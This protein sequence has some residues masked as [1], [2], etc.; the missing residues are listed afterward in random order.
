MPTQIHKPRRKSRKTSKRKG[1]VAPARPSRLLSIDEAAE[2]L[3]VAKVT[4]RRWTNTG[5]LRCV[6]MCDRGDRRFRVE[7]L[8]LFIRLRL[9]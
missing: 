3:G 7:D 5:I 2:W 1:K 6:R 9:K 4:I 8:D